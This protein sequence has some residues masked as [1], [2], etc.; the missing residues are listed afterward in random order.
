MF[1]KICMLST[2]LALAPPAFAADSAA[3]DTTAKDVARKLGETGDTIR[4]FT[5][6]QRDEAVRSAKAGLDDLD[7]RIGRMEADLERK[8]DKMDQR[9]RQQ[10]R[11]ALDALHRQRN[12]LSEWYGGLKHG[13]TEAWDEVKSG[14]A[15]SYRTLRDSFARAKEKF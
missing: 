2:V 1:W 9:A 10:A 8:C 7:A 14:F 3:D 11:E 13:S 6:E 4:T 12:E 5:I 15:E